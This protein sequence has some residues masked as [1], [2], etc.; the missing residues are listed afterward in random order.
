MNKYLPRGSGLA[1]RGRPKDRR[2][3][4]GGQEEARAPVLALLT[5]GSFLAPEHTVGGG[6]PCLTTRGTQT[7]VVFTAV[8]PYESPAPSQA[9]RTTEQLFPKCFVLV[10]LS[11]LTRE[12]RAKSW[13]LPAPG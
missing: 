3:Q 9:G 11:S 5:M 7:A 4:T 6:F 13:Y 8:P 1:F 10:W 12:Q 2:R